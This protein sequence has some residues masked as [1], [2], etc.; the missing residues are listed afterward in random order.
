MGSL[1]FDCH[2]GWG[3]VNMILRGV[4]ERIHQI[5][6]LDFVAIGCFTIQP[7]Y[8]LATRTAALEAEDGLTPRRRYLR[9]ECQV[10]VVM[11][12]RPISLG[13]LPVLTQ[14]IGKIQ[15][16][17]GFPF[18]IVVELWPAHIVRFPSSAM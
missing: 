2:T 5:F 17:L 13:Q 9:L 3:Y 18:N 7:K 11:I 16:R 12:E 8:M 4:A 6:K 10:A 15:L 14:N 1:C